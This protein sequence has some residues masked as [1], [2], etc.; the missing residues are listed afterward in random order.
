MKY[1]SEIKEKIVVFLRNVNKRVLF[2]FFLVLIAGGF[3][4][5]YK[6]GNQS[7]IAD[8]YLGINASYGYYKTGEWKF[9]DFNKNEI[10]EQS[11]IRANI[12]YWQ[13]AQVFKFFPANEMSARLVSVFWGIIG[14]ISV[15]FVSYLVT[16]NYYIALLAAFLASISISSLTFDRKLRMYAM[17]A[18]VYLWLSYVV[19]CF[20]ESR[21]KRGF[22]AIKKISEKTELNW[23]FFLPVVFL[24]IIAIFVHIISVN[25]FISILF[26]LVVMF[27]LEY[28]KSKIFLN[29]YSLLFFP[30]FFLVIFLINLKELKGALAFFSWG[31]NNW[32]YLQKIT[33]DYS[34]LLLAIV[35]LLLGCFFLIKKHSKI[36]L[37]MVVSYL[38]PVFLAIMFWKRSAGDQYIFF[39]QLLKIVI[40]ASGIFYVS[41]MLSEKIFNQS[42]KWLIGLVLLFLVLLINFSF[43]TSAE[44]FYGNRIKWNYSN[45][46]E[47]LHYFLKH[48]KENSVLIARPA[49]NF[50]IWGSNS[51]L[52]EYNEKEGEQLTL[53]KIKSAQEKFDD[54][55]IIFAETYY[56]E[57]DAR[58]YFKKTFNKVETSYTNNELEVWRWQRNN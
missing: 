47:V 38:V 26:Y 14:I 28:R 20:L 30:A 6:L 23:N 19:F 4:R 34:H 50:Y 12:Y 29:K 48:R 25:I 2:L 5:L 55:W 18:P 11:Y 31:I 56:M 39:T 17:I 35:F 9:W 42:K 21:V 52:I 22:S 27:L 1:F 37:W 49:T 16:K 46:R 43:F 58:N 7:F 8:E 45:Y 10:T 32:S 54:I 33:L 24:G 53:E 57:S 3:L 51:N 13:V 15:F 36:G 40:M 44:S 41:E